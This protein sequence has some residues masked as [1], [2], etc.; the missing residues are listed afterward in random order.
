[1]RYLRPNKSNASP[2]NLAWFDCET[3]PDNGGQPTDYGLHKLHFGCATTCRLEAGE[4]TRRKELHFT[5]QAQFWFWL[6][7]LTRKKSCLWVF[8]HNLGFDATIIGL[9]ERIESGELKFIFPTPRRNRKGEVISKTKELTP[10][11]ILDDPPTVIQVE[12]GDGNQY[13]FIDTLNYWRCSLSTLGKGIGLE[14]LEM[15]PADSPAATWKAYCMRDVEIIERAVLGLI[16]WVRDEELGKFRLTSPS[17]AMAAY[18][19]RFMQHRILYHDDKIVRNLER[20]SYY[21]GQVEC[22]LL[23][24]VNRRIHQ[25]D[26]TSLYPSVMRGNLYPWR[27]SSYVSREKHGDTIPF[28]RGMDKIAEVMIDTYDRTYPRRMKD[29]IYHCSGRFFT[30]LC[31]PELDYALVHNHVKQ[32]YNYATFNIS[33]L[34]SKYVDFFWAKRLEYKQ[35]NN[36]LGDILC[37]LLLNS[38]Y[39]KFGQNGIEWTTI[40]NNRFEGK[41][42][43]FVDSNLAT[44]KTTEYRIIG[45]VCQM[46]IEREEIDNAFPAIAAYV[47]AYGRELMRGLR[48]IAGETHIYYQA[49]DALYVDDI[50]LENLQAAGAVAE[51]QLGK[52]H[53]ESS[54][55][56]AEFRG[57]NNYRIGAKEV[58]GSI[59]S[60]AKQIAPNTWE[61]PQ[62]Q[63]LASVLSK[64]L[65]GGV[66]ISKRIKTMQNSYT[67]RTLQA[68]QLTTPIYLA[69]ETTP[70]QE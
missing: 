46:K 53:L 55:D 69:D 40:P 63:H 37:K 3:L 9:W 29:G 68:S 44:G 31:G 50:G 42:G 64:P 28:T 14:K 57:I 5:T 41:W 18:R 61:E 66:V 13:K 12:D 47:T 54:A 36:P 34:F 49:V 56:S 58:R 51:K 2:T 10:L 48:E 26:V 8:A 62:F 11:L 1:M 15:P 60:M 45:N 22:Y 25:L 20:Q 7:T 23:G 16:K 32:V 19:H 65:Q 38:L 39:G 30:T 35:C 59:K 52:F 33:E 24:R 67:R 17:Q 21:G 27:L 4:V 43:K 70:Y 6:K